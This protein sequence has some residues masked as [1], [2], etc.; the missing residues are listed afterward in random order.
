[1]SDQLCPIDTFSTNNQISDVWTINSRLVNEARLGFMGEYDTW[2]PETYQQGWPGK[3]GL[4]FAKADIFPNI[5]ITSYYGLA[6]GVHSQY[7]ENLFDISD[8]VTFIKGRH[9]FHAGG[10]LLIE[11]A[12]STIYG[13]I[14]SAALSFTGAYSAGSNTGSLATST[15]SPYADFLFWAI[16]RAGLP[17]L[18][19]NT[20]A[21]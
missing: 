13:N 16:Q 1:M 9:V 18:H 12:D 3:L 15:G 5:T 14:T 21:G 4:K 6:S 19:R 2:T 8:V 17:A 20:A 10:E 7:K 11:R